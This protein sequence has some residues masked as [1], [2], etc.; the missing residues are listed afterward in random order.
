MRKIGGGFELNSEINVTP[1]VDVVL[2]LLIIFMVVIPLTLK[3]YD[4]DI[5]GESVQ[6][7][8]TDSQET[9][10]Q[11]VMTID[12]NGCPLTAPPT[13]R[14][15]PDNCTVRLND[16]SVPVGQLTARIGEIFNPRAEEDRVLFLA[17]HERM[18]YEAVMRIVDMAK[19]GSHGLRIGLVAELAMDPAPRG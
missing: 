18:N 6:G 13:T 12:L 17:A 4:L 14:S 1:L 10:E 7:S 11:F 5:P 16:E 9:P 2:V 15:L 3:G 8:V 19:G